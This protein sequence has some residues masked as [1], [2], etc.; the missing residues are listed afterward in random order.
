MGFEDYG[1]D[2]DDDDCGGDCG[3]DQGDGDCGDDSD[4]VVVRPLT[5]SVSSESTSLSLCLLSGIFW[6]AE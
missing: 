2:C 4:E 3:G 6:H 5:E 1:D